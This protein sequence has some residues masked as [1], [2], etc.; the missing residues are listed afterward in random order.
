MIPG[1]VVCDL[2]GTLIRVSSE[3]AFLMSLA[4]RRILRASGVA[5]FLAGYALH[6]SRT[7]REGPGWNRRYLRGIPAVCLSREADRLT[8]ILLETVR[9]EVSAYLEDLGRKGARLHLL[10]ASLAPLVERISRECGFH[11]FTGSSPEIRDGRFTGDIR[12]LRPWGPGKVA[13]L[14]AIMEATGVPPGDTL[15]LGNSRSDI[16]MMRL[17][18][19]AAAVVPDSGLKAEASKRGWEVLE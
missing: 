12:G 19:A 5:G 7:I 13:A 1:L 14:R 16:E 18:G 9:P 6:P 17:C 8:P 11:G 2:D 3:R 10:S 15:A 4:R